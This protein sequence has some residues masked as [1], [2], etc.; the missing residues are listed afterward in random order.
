MKW[1]TVPVILCCFAVPSTGPAAQPIFVGDLGQPQ[2]FHL[3]G[4][5]SFPPEQILGKLADDLDLL[6]ELCPDAL[7]QNLLAMIEQRLTSSYRELGFVDATVSATWNEREQRI[8]IHLSEGIRVRWRDVVVLGLPEEVRKTVRNSVLDGSVRKELFPAP[9]KDGEKQDT[10]EAALTPG[11]WVNASALQ[12]SRSLIEKGLA[13][14]ALMNAQ[15][16]VRIDNDP[17]R[18]QA[19]LVVDVSDPGPLATFSRIDILGCERQSPEEI[20]KFV[21]IRPGEA[22][23][24]QA[25]EQVRRRLWETGRFRHCQ[26][27]LESP[28]LP[29][30]SRSLLIDVDE[31]TTA[32]R[33]EEP[34]DEMQQVTVR[35]ARWVSQADQAGFDLVL[36]AEPVENTSE[37][38]PFWSPVTL[39]VS[40]MEGTLLELGYSVSKKTSE[41]SIALLFSPGSL[42]VVARG[43]GRG[44]T[45]PMPAEYG[46]ETSICLDGIP[47]RI[48]D[49]KESSLSF[50]VKY[51]A[52]RHQA[53]FVLL[54]LS[55]SPM[56]ALRAL[57]RNRHFV[58]WNATDLVYQD[59]N[60]RIVI[61]AASGRI[62]ESRIVI[63]KMRCSLQFETHRSHMFHQQIPGSSQIQ[64]LDQPVTIKEVV[65]LVQG[66]L[67]H[68]DIPQDHPER[69][70]WQAIIRL[71]ARYTREVSDLKLQFTAD[72][73][74]DTFQM[75]SS[76]TGQGCLQLMNRMTRIF[77]A[78]SVLQRLFRALN[79]AIARKDPEL[80][81]RS[82]KQFQKPGTGGLTHL[83]AAA[84]L[85]PVFP[86][87]ADRMAKQGLECLDED[88]FRNDL[89]LLLKDFPAANEFVTQTGGFLR[90]N[91]SEE[92]QPIL[93]GVITPTERKELEERAG[94]SDI[95]DRQFGELI[96]V[97]LWRYRGR[98]CVEDLLQQLCLPQ[99][100]AVAMLPVKNSSNT[101]RV[102]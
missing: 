74:E 86:Q 95:T 61:E 63:N 55:I 17:S 33:L 5:E 71:A 60:S 8:E 65:S 16:E 59:G 18:K 102:D 35:A 14:H 51:S 45:F 64:K 40:P 1:L 21:A 101:N 91:Q 42:Q 47:G 96:L 31:W 92:L 97:L 34:L 39:I 62:K 90:T 32:P 69:R 49:G 94:D 66:V 89:Q 3:V 88:R 10:G 58:T 9:M 81:S 72:S 57:E 2:L 50:G 87:G 53:N 30:D 84:M 78:D 85:K 99:S 7:L 29:G 77:P 100:S 20:M 15:F 36:K 44:L 73:D 83:L 98:D 75:A 70:R 56:F 82:I 28:L 80:I 4:A 12:K 67:D 48:V 38:S 13:C 37:K 19:D 23:T 41:S 22:C 26:V 93:D 52:N 76:V 68:L 79:I 6:P 46:C 43:V 27:S 25:M 54:N 24:A 11:K